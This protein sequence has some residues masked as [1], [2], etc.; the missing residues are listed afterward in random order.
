MMQ[1]KDGTANEAYKGFT[2]HECPF[3]PCHAGVKRAFNCLF[4]YCPLI[5][6]ECPGP[7]RIYTDKHGLRRKDCSDCRLPHEGYQA[8]WSFIQKWLERP[9]IWGGRE[10]DARERKAARGG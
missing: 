8:S 10:L 5:A 3:Y 2:N 6:Y 1:P 7:Y 9:R 4:C